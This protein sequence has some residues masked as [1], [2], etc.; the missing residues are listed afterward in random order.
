MEGKRELGNHYE[1]VAARYLQS[2]GV[3]IIA[4]NVYN[5][6]G[7]IDLIGRDGDTLVFFE[8]RFRGAG[9]LTSPLDSITRSKTRTLVR[10]VSYY[11]HRHGLWN[12]PSRIDVVGIMPGTAKKYRVQWIK[13]AIQAE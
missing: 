1:G 12:Q 5:R 11:L 2:R 9:S 3:S 8:V 4:R 13:N 7:E 6:G 10:A